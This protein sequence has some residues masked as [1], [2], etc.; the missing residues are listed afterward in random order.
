MHVQLCFKPYRRSCRDCAKT[1][2]STCGCRK[3]SPRPQRVD[4]SPRTS[5]HDL[6]RHR[7]HH[8]HRQRKRAGRMTAAA[9]SLD[10]RLQRLRET[11]CRG[12]RGRDSCAD[13]RAAGRADVVW[14][15]TR[16]DEPGSRT[17]TETSRRTCR[18]QLIPVQ[19]RTDG[20]NWT[21]VK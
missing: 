15:W 18:K 14:R 16:A 7:H 11:T 8:H 19:E 10:I 9:R 1:R 3:A 6:P 5:P 17:S 21:K 2:R 4:W 13:D 20:Q 12:C